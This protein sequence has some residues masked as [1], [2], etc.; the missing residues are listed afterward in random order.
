MIVVERKTDK[1]FLVIVKEELEKLNAVVKI[2]TV[3]MNE[4]ERAKFMKMSQEKW[5][6]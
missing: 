5:R 2:N 4:E 1:E 6:F 3:Q